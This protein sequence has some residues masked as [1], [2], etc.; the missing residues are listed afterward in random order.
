MNVLLLAS[1]TSLSSLFRV[2]ETNTWEL[3][4][5]CITLWQTDRHMVTILLSVEY[6][7]V[8][9]FIDRL[10]FILSKVVHS[11]SVLKPRN[12]ISEKD[13]MNCSTSSST[14]DPRSTF[15]LLH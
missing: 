1:S 6:A 9:V 4:S 2:G 13:T 10:L 11:S 14:P 8:V 7:A 5:Y 3:N 12:K 15:C